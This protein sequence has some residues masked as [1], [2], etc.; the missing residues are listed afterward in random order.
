MKLAFSLES[1]AGCG[2]DEGLATSAALAEGQSH[3]D[4]AVEIFQEVRVFQAVS[5]YC[6]DSLKHFRIISCSGFNLMLN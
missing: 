1:W 2:G 5:K 6:V 3:A 4:K